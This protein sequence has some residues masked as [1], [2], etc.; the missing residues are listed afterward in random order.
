MERAASGEGM[1]DEQV[2]STLQELI[3]FAHD[4]FL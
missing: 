4:A 3:G 2:E 1:E